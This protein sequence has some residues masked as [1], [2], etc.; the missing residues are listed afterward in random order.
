MKYLIEEVREKK[1]AK[2][3]FKLAKNGYDNTLVIYLVIFE[4]LN[5][6]PGSY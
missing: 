6:R 4:V 2:L 5:G 1:S 3:I